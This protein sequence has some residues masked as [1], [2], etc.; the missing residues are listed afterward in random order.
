MFED[1]SHVVVKKTKDAQ[2]KEQA[3]SEAN[4]TKQKIEEVISSNFPQLKIND[5]IRKRFIINVI[6]GKEPNIESIISNQDIVND[7]NRI[8][9]NY[10][11]ATENREKLLQDAIA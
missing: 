4:E 1:L 7:L 2:A 3:D 5:N 6:T 11:K 9:D 8:K 10:N